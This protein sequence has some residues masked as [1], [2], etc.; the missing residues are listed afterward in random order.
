[1]RGVQESGAAE[2]FSEGGGGWWWSGTAVATFGTSKPS[3]AV[4]RWFF[5]TVLAGQM[6]SVCLKTFIL[7][8]G[9]NELAE[10][11]INFRIW[12]KPVGIQSSE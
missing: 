12:R 4:N 10:A 7:M 2:T 1:M 9:H 8:K 6:A 3:P 5:H 11:E